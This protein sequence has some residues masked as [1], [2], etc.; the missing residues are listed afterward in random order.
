MIGETKRGDPESLNFQAHPL[1]GRRG[2][3]CT[4]QARDR[5]VGNAIICVWTLPKSLDGLMQFSEANRPLYTVL[6]PRPDR[7]FLSIIGPCLVMKLL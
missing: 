7:L 5:Q 3:S 4:L 1:I 2:R 6:Y